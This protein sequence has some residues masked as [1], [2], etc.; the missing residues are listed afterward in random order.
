[1]QMGIGKLGRPDIVIKRKF[2]WTLE[3]NTPFG[4]V[5]RH[6]V[7]T[8]GRPQLDIDETEINF[9]NGVTWIPGKGKWQPLSCTYIDVADAEMAKLYSWV[10]TVYD[11][12]QQNP[13]DHIPQSEKTGWNGT[14]ELIM[15]DG[16]G[17][18]IDKF[19]LRS[20]WPQSISFGDLD[21]SDSAE[22]TIDLTLRFS[23]VSYQ[24]L[25]SCAG[26]IQARCTGCG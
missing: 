4:Q 21:Y 17:N 18:P 22:V 3:I 6:Y 5:P 11:F 15:Y 10:A 24:S 20:C 13:I 1:M 14:A 8:S 26:Q 12:S 16:C 9:L 25:G 23:E 2:R 7:K 19:T